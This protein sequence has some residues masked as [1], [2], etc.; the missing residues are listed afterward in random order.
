MV[1]LRLKRMGRK[2]RPFYRIVAMTDNEPR[3]GQALAELGTYDPI[4]SA[5]AVDEEATLQWLN[6]G[7][8]MTETVRDL[9]HNKGVLA[10]WRGFPGTERTGVLSGPKPKRRKKLAS[11]APAGEAE[12]AA[13]DAAAEGDAAP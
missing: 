8:Q 1:K 13:A 9:L 3:S 6:R 2:K 4:H 7:A 11:A 12:G 5:F 10:R